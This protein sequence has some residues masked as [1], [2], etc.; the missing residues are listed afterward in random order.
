MPRSKFEWCCNKTETFS[1]W[2]I[3]CEGCDRS[4]DCGLCR[5]FTLVKSKSNKNN[6]REK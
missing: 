6:G 4:V 3:P 5:E 2:I 1:P